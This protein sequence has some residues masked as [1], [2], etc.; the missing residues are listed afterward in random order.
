M[1]RVPQPL[2]RDLSRAA[3]PPMLG[4]GTWRA[5]KGQVG[6]AVSHAIRAGYRHI[7]AAWAYRNE[8]EVGAAIKKSLINRKE[9]WLTTKV[10]N[11]FHAPEHVEKG[12]DASL[13]DLGTDYVDLLLMHWPVAF[14]NPKGEQ[15]A[16]IKDERSGKPIEDVDL[17]QNPLA[18]WQAMEELVKK[19]KV[20]HIGIS[21]FNIRRT[22]ELLPHTKIRPT[23][24]Q[25]EVNLLCSNEE[26]RLASLRE[27]ITLEAYSP[28]GS[29]ENIAK[30]ISHPVVQ[31]I[32][33][34]L[35]ATPAQVLL[36]WPMRRGIV[37]LAKSVKPTRIEENW[38][39]WNVAESLKEDDLERLLGV[40]KGHSQIVRTVNPTQAWGVQDDIFED[41]VDQLRL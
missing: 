18:T 17:S 16:N 3:A 38:G 23:F 2:V 36:A 7:D 13:K 1:V 21:N 37:T 14:S 8:D 30:Y 11:S 34:R 22:R 26:L 41:G 32:A 24:N 20:R 29:A 25:V 31:D 9:L 4:L 15:V 28:L 27:N 40:L 33:N 39:A 10:W 19:G 5:P 12:V 35:H 6:D